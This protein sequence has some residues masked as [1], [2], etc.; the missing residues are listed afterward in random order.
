MSKKIM[1]SILCVFILGVFPAQAGEKEHFGP[2]KPLFIG[3]NVDLG[4]LYGPYRPEL[5]FYRSE[6]QSALIHQ[7]N[8][9]TFEFAG[10]KEDGAL[11]F[12]V[13]GDRFSEEQADLFAE[14]LNA[15]SPAAGIQFTMDFNL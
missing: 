14:G 15:I 6:S 8:G 10:K 4:A 7:E 2:F 12:F 9:V 1:L 5:D 3:L 13:S 11:R